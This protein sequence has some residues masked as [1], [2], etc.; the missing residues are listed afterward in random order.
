MFYIIATLADRE[1]PVTLPSGKP[2]AFETFAIAE[3]VAATLRARVHV[4]QYRVVYL[5]DSVVHGSPKVEGE[6][7]Q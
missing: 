5:E 7:D 3:R 4:T 1:G 2:R 6:D